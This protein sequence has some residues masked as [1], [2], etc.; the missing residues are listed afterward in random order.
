MS[1]SVSACTI[2]HEGR[3]ER[4]RKKKVEV[5]RDVSPTV[6]VSHS[7]VPL[8]SATGL[9]PYMSGTGVSPRNQSEVSVT[10]IYYRF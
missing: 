1:A 9:S 2:S 8:K 6:G 4:E 7:C 5:V 3:T 10:R